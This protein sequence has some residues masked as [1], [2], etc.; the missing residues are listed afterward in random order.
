MTSFGLQKFKKLKQ[1]ECYCFK[2]LTDIMLILVK[3]IF[4]LYCLLDY[5]ALTNTQSP[6][7]V[8]KVCTV[9]F[10]KRSKE[11]SL[12]YVEKQCLLSKNTCYILVQNCNKLIYQTF[13]KCH[14]K[15]D[16]IWNINVIPNNAND[17]YLQENIILPA[18]THFTLYI[19]N[20]MSYESANGLKF[21][22][23]LLYQL[24]EGQFSEIVLGKSEP[25]YVCKRI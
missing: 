23:N 4:I 9:S 11:I 14:T 20:Q 8:V 12:A 6:T 18:E 17:K 22:K 2:N 13:F 10:L 1:K 7:F 16:R 15:Y 24:I 3:R 5:S 25:Q 19:L 21:S